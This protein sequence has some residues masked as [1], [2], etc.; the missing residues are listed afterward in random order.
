MAPSESEEMQR[1]VLAVSLC[2]CTTFQHST[3]WTV[4]NHYVP[5]QF[6]ILTH[7]NSRDSINFLFQQIL[8]NCKHFISLEF[9]LPNLFQ[10]VLATWY[11]FSFIFIYLLEGR[12]QRA[13]KNPPDKQRRSISAR[14]ID[15]MLFSFT[16]G[17]EDVISALH[18][19]I[20]CQTKAINPVPVFFYYKTRTFSNHHVVCPAKENHPYFRKCLLSCSQ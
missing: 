16:K 12:G 2:P 4:Q 18:L 7:V 3:K 5:T 9:R 13:L 14:K 10:A 20:I 15:G 8:L 11:A 17:N 6:D 19:T 1:A